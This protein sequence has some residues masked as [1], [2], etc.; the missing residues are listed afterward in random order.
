MDLVRAY[1]TISNSSVRHGIAETI[2]AIAATARS[3]RRRS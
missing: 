1:T 3:N 2:Q